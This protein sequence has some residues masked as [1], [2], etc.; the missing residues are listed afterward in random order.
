MILLSLGG[1]VLDPNKKNPRHKEAKKIVQFTQFGGKARYIWLECSQPL[2]FLWDFFLESSSHIL[3]T[4]VKTQDYLSLAKPNTWSDQAEEVRK[5]PF[6]PFTSKT[7]SC[8]ACSTAC[9]RQTVELLRT[10]TYYYWPPPGISF[11]PFEH[12]SDKTSY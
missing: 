6:F 4:Q 12:N 2:G 7:S 11:H 3:Q 8:H 10:G 5:L 1:G 9:K